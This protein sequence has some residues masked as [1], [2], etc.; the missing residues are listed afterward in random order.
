MRG[1]GLAGRVGGEPVIFSRTNS[2]A[3]RIKA[4]LLEFC[5]EGEEELIVAVGTMRNITK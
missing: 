1:E 2:G 4:T 5:E 3:G